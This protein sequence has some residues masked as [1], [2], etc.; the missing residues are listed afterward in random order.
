MALCSLAFGCLNIHKHRKHPPLEAPQ[1][2]GTGDVTATLD[3]IVQTHNDVKQLLGGEV[4]HGD[5]LVPVE[6]IGGDKK[7]ACDNNKDSDIH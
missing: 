3:L 1:P 5:L 6:W 2:F 7:N 4:F